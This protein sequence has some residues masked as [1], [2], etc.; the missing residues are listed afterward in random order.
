LRPGRRQ[1]VPAPH[2]LRHPG[3]GAAPV[4]GNVYDELSE[5]HGGDE[6]W[7]FGTGFTDA[8]VEG[9]APAPDG[10][11]GGEPAQYCLMLRDGPLTCAERLGGGVAGA[12]ELEEGVALA[13]IG[14]AL[15]G[16][17]RLLLSRAGHFRGRGEDRL[18]YWRAEPEFR[19]V[20]LAELG[21]DRDFA[22]AIARLL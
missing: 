8:G 10:V 1:G 11:H 18:A 4:T 2:V 21:D 13:N 3:R 7:A 6:H 22:R 20:A 5:A 12:P 14:L 16:Q 19:N 9:T 17:A 15:P